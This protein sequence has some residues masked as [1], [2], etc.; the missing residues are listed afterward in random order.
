MV[1]DRD[2]LMSFLNENDIFPGVHYAS[3]TDYKMYSYAKKTC[4]KAEYA[5][6]HIISLPLHMRLSYDDVQI[7]IKHVI[8]FITR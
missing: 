2:G 8:D 4:P 7:I 5:S 3:N 6:D 1:D